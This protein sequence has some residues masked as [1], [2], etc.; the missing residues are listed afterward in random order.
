MKVHRMRIR[1]EDP[2]IAPDQAQAIA[3]RVSELVTG[4]RVADRLESADRLEPADGLARHVA[5]S[6]SNA[7][8]AAGE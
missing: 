5:G 1:F 6:V 2:H 4:E 3:R 8:R 7:L